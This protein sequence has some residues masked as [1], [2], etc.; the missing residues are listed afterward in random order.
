MTT[1]REE[2][3]HGAGDVAAIR[4]VVE[5]AFE[6]RGEADLVDALREAATSYISLVAIDVGEIVGH[7]CFS[8][9]TIG[10]TPVSASLDAH[11]MRAISPRSEERGPASCMGLAPLAVAPAAQRRGIGSDL[12]RAGLEQCRRR[13]HAAV[14]VLGHPAYYP[15]FGFVPAARYGLRCEYSVPDDTFMALELAVGALRDR[16]GLVRYHAAF[17]SV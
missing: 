1:I 10:E 16:S 12:V 11:G 9:V 4:A 5:A 3:E 14:V 6:R 2:R 7:I 17:A 15:R 8:P 13:G